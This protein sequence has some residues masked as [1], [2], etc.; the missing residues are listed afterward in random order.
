REPDDAAA[1]EV[2]EPDDI[3]VVDVDRVGLRRPGQ[4]PLA[5][6]PRRGVVA[7][8]LAGVPLADPQ[9]PAGVR[10]DPTCALAR[11]RGASDG[12]LAGRRVD[13]GAVASRE[14]RVPDVP[15]RR[16]GDPVRPDA[17]RRAEDA[18]RARLGLEPTV[19]PALAREPEDA[20]A[21][22]GRGVEV[23]VAG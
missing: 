10:P 18:H 13:P 17:T 23:C 19:D 6:T 15:A 16:G 20:L 14:G 3:A 12:G 4:A 8:H 21:I 5:P 2:R 22:E 11:R 9:P 1:A 7:R